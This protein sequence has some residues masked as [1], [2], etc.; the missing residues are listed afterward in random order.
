MTDG[1]WQSTDFSGRLEGK[2]IFL[3]VIL[4]WHPESSAN[5]WRFVSDP[6][7]IIPLMRS[8]QLSDD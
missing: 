1:R 6:G 3:S 7:Y 8:D 2:P 5:L 4:I